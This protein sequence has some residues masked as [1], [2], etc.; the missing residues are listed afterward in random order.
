M[1]RVNARELNRKFKKCPTP[2]TAILELTN[3]CTLN[4]F[5]CIR[6]ANRL[7]LSNE[8]STSDWLNVLED[9][10]SIQTFSICF[11]GGEA[12]EHEGFFE[13]A[14]R[15]RELGMVT[16]LKTNGMKL[17]EFKSKLKD[18]GI[19]SVD[20]SLYGSNSETHD[21]ITGSKGS[22]A[23]SIEGIKSI[24]E[25]GIPVHIS[26]LI[27][28]ANAAESEEMRFLAN[29]LDATIQR[30]F[31]LMPTDCGKELDDSFITPVQIREVEEAWPMS[32]LPSNQNGRDGIKVCA[33]G[34]NVISITASGDILSC[35]LLR[36]PLGNVKEEGIRRIWAEASSQP[37]RTHNLN[38][39]LFKT[40][41]DCNL[42]P[43]CYICIGQN[44]TSTGSFYEPPLERCYITMALFG[45][46]L[47][48]EETYA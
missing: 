11:S 48:K 42:L 29:K 40:C 26:Y 31:F 9:L 25:E 3:R 35:E 21:S 8:L 5:H 23:R 12:L 20:V 22:F 4:C 34:M 15:A 19:G 32:S 10:R 37:G 14:V 27:M 18:V 38:F 24:R 1:E 17:S 47:Q 46:K 44:Y 2:S 45:N 30:D 43:Q 41:K 6:E 39:L 33:Q 16:T 28:R 36:K 13:L 7:N